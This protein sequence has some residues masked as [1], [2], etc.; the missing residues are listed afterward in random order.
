MSEPRRYGLLADFATPEALVDATRAAREA[1]YSRLEAY[2]P[3]PVE[4]LEQL[5]GLNDRRAL[6]YGV[7]GAVVGAILGYAMQVYANLD[8]PLNTGGRPLIAVPAF[9][10][11]TFLMAVLFAVLFAVFG[12]FWLCRLPLLHHPLFEAEAFKRAMDDRFLLCIHGDDPRFDRLGT[13]LWLAERALTVTEIR[14]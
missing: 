5:L 6:W 9:M 12:L 7:A 14:A 1:G 4:A 11:V 2:T 8:Y 10:V 13:S 3:F